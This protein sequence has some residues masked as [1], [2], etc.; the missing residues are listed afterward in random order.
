MINY[1]YL[2]SDLLLKLAI[3]IRLFL[4]GFQKNIID[5]SFVFLISLFQK[6][7]NFK[8]NNIKLLIIFFLIA[9]NANLFIK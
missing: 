3:F 8:T 4:Y 6:N 9:K 5:F 2:F 1:I 7:I